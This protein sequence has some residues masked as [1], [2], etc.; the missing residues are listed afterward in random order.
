[1]MS[2]CHQGNLLHPSRFHACKITYYHPEV[3]EKINK[4]RLYTRLTSYSHRQEHHWV[5]FLSGWGET[6]VEKTG[7]LCKVTAHIAN[8]EVIDSHT[9]WNDVNLSLL[10]DVNLFCKYWYE[11]YILHR[12]YFTTH[13]FHLG[14]GT[15]GQSYMKPFKQNYSVFLIHMLIQCL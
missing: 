1:M 8:L 13:I 2:Q 9:R 14:M 12:F 15:E 11:M 7:H 3:K 10:V 5:L 6:I 4:A